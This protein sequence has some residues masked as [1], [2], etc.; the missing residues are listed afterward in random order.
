MDNRVKKQIKKLL[1]EEDLKIVNLVPM[2]SEKTG[3]QYVYDNFIH[4]LG[5]ATITYEE[6]LDIADILGYEIKF[7]KKEIN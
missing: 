6:M 7:V 2:L 4:R 3:K 1:L 5:R